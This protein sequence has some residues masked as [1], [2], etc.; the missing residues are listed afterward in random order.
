VASLR[1][2]ATNLEQGDLT[3]LRYQC[4]ASGRAF[5]TQAPI[6]PALAFPEPRFWYLSNIKSR[7][8]KSH[9]LRPTINARVSIVSTS[10]HCYDL[11]GS[12]QDWRLVADDLLVQF[13]CKL[14]DDSFHQLAVGSAGYEVYRLEKPNL[15]GL[16]RRYELGLGSGVRPLAKR[17]RRPSGDRTFNLWREGSSA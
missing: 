14:K 4:P 12:S 16:A 5:R 2:R 9:R 8:G 17:L 3:R 6:P 7:R 13:G 10:V 11:E 15:E 1:E